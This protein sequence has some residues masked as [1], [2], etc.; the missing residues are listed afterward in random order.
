[1]FSLFFFYSI[2]TPPCVIFIE[3]AKTIVNNFTILDHWLLLYNF[4]RNCRSE[5]SDGLESTHTLKG[6]L[7]V[8]IEK[9]LISKFK[10]NTWL[11]M[12][13]ERL[14]ELFMISIL[15]PYDILCENPQVCCGRGTLG[16]TN[17]ENPAAA[18]VSL[19]LTNS[20]SFKI[21][22]TGF[23]VSLS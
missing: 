17:N 3:N 12:K 9:L 19:C 23:L 21:H 1:M 7:P 6:T 10:C 20:K 15:I 13:W 8:K 4:W 18:R 22:S 11:Q 2:V 16:L 14:K 5:N